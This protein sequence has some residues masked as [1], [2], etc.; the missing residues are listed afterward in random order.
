[1]WRRGDGGPEIPLRNIGFAHLECV[2]EELL[3]R[4][5]SI[6]SNALSLIEANEAI[7]YANVRL[8]TA[9]LEARSYSLRTLVSPARKD[10][11]KHSALPENELG[12]LLNSS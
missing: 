7:T 2:V 1:M 3:K 6:S 8:K 10:L 11:E 12:K 4:C 5:Q 9:G